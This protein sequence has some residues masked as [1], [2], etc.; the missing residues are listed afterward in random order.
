MNKT[1]E[2]LCF[3]H[4]KTPNEYGF[5]AIFLNIGSDSKFVVQSRT[6]DRSNFMCMPCENIDLNSLFIYKVEMGPGKMLTKCFDA[7]IETYL[8]ILGN[9]PLLDRLQREVDIISDCNGI[10]LEDEISVSDV[11]KKR[12]SDIR[13]SKL[14]LVLD[15]IK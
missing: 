10:D 11:L 15:E 5:L 7:P 1:E 3:L 6:S 13:D 4:S 9:T 2:V 12:I 14:N 8:N